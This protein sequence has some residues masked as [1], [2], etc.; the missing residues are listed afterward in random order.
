VIRAQHSPSC[1]R[2]ARFPTQ[3]APHCASC[4]ESPSP[5]SAYVWGLPNPGQPVNGLVSFPLATC[6]SGTLDSPLVMHPYSTQITGTTFTSP[7]QATSTLAL[8]IINTFHD[9]THAASSSY[10]YLSPILSSH[11][12][13]PMLSGADSLDGTFT[14]TSSLPNCFLARL[15][16]FALLKF[17]RPASLPPFSP[18]FSLFA[19][20]ELRPQDS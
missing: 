5:S 1:K 16:L 2:G 4:G 13:C 14:P 19:R 20:L 12:L 15:P 3:K 17:L 7:T 11:C 6:Y 18:S 9:V 10:S 8:P